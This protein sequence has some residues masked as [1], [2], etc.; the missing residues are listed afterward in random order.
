[1]KFKI[2]EHQKNNITIV[3]KKLVL[4]FILVP[5]SVFAKFYDGTVTYNDGTTKTGLIEIPEEGGK[6][7]IQLKPI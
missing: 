4:L 3:R 6:Q 7:E 1:M 5:F 2:Q